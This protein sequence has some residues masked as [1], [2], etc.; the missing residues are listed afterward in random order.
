MR[1]GN[2]RMSTSTDSAD[3]M[4]LNDQH[5]VQPS[6][7]KFGCNKVSSGIQEFKP[8]ILVNR[9]QPSYRSRSDLSRL[10]NLQ[11]WNHPCLQRLRYRTQT[12]TTCFTCSYGNLWRSQ[13]EPQ[14]HGKD[15]NRSQTT[16][17]PEPS[18]QA[19]NLIQTLRHAF[20]CRCRGLSSG[21]AGT[22]SR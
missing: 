21:R 17:D 1:G 20:G 13:A 3:G 18:L 9:R 5:T 4:A 2:I 10:Y 14:Q 6:A 12:A 19:V 22:V 8:Q 15:G 16:H 11:T 7:S